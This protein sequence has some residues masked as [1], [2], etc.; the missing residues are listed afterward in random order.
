MRRGLTRAGAATVLMLLAVGSLRT[1]DRDKDNDQSYAKVHYTKHQYRV[2]MRDG[3]TLYTSVYF[4]KDSTHQYPIM[5][6]RT[7]YGVAPYD[8]EEYKKTVGPTDEFMREGFIF[9]Y[10]DVRGAWMSEG[11]YV[12]VRPLCA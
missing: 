6:T 1:Q 10:Q 4:P 2:P 9:V 8:P 5:L 3:A 12:D 7:P 11:H